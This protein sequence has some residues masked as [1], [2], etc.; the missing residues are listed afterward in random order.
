MNVALIANTAWLDEDLTMF[1][2]LVV[3]LI[4]DQ[5]QVV[6]VVPE[7][8]AE[9]EVSAFCRH[10]SWRDSRWESVRRY[11]LGRLSDRLQNMDIDVIHA[12]DGRVWSGALKL[13]RRNWTPVVLGASSSMDVPQVGRVQRASRSLKVA[14]V[15]TTQPLAEAIRLKLESNALVEVVSQGIQ[16]PDSANSRPLD[17]SKLCAAVTGNGTYD[18]QYEALMIA[19]R[20]IITK[21]PQ[22][23]F[24][25][26]GQGN[27][28]RLLWQAAQRYG[29][30]SNM[31]L[32]PRRLGHRELLLRADL[33]IQPQSLGR[34]RTLTLRAMAHGVPVL[35]MSDSW[36]DYLIDQQTAWVIEKPDPALWVS[37]IEQFIEH[38][39][40][41]RQ[42]TNRA[43]QWVLQRHRAAVQVEHMV[44][45][46]REISGESIKFS[47][48]LK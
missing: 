27:D 47:E 5:V 29:L 22:A 46:Y 28:Q 39:D 10:V 36:L 40:D 43:R 18:T 45:L 34:S 48:A 31:S 42:R 37:S 17:G 41:A 3:G 25:F 26:D 44:Q 2:C 12:L 24:F 11:R 13:A 6:E 1:Q 20:S 7:G 23:Q 33:L 38:R 35:A 16:M 15:A 8:L 19:M 14:F 30:L 32:V 21:Y 4:D 9:T